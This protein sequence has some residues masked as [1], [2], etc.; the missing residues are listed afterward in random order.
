MQREAAFRELGLN[1]DHVGAVHILP[2]RQAVG[3]DLRRFQRQDGGCGDP[4]KLAG[5]GQHIG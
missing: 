3:D 2:V 5:V 1:C 4:A